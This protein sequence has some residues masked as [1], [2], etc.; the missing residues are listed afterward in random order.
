M[1][2]LARCDHPN[3]VRYFTAWPGKFDRKAF[4]LGSK[5]D[6]LLKYLLVSCLSSGILTRIS[7]AVYLEY[8]CVSLH[9][10]NA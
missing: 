7:S 6:Q 10:L 3:I 1:K 4:G 8:Y 9:L 5:Y 2:A